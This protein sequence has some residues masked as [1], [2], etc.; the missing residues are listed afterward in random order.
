MSSF[1]L[2]CIVGCIIGCA[3]IAIL[4][5]GARS[6]LTRDL[7]RVSADLATAK[8]ALSESNADRD[9][10]ISELKR[11][12]AIIADSRGI[13]EDLEKQGGDGLALIDK[14]IILARRLEEGLRETD[15]KP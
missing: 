1:A 6:D 9:K 2:G 10:A 3:T 12:D 15:K 4:G 8:S 5:M 13:I 11:V 7:D 14:C